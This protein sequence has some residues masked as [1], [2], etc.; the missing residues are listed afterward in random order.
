MRSSW[1]SCYP[2]DLKELFS[3]LQII[4]SIGIMELTQSTLGCVTDKPLQECRP[5]FTVIIRILRGYFLLT[6]DTWSF[7]AGWRG[8]VKILLKD[9]TNVYV[10]VWR[11]WKCKLL[12]VKSQGEIIINEIE[13]ELC[14]LVLQ[15]STVMWCD[16][17]FDCS[18][19]MPPI[20]PSPTERPPTHG[21][22]RHL[23]KDCSHIWFRIRLFLNLRAQGWRLLLHSTE[24]GFPRWLSGK[25]SACQ[26]RRHKRH[27]FNPW[28]GKISWR[29]E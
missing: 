26:C 21:K 1:R 28:V 23:V 27:G 2:S 17:R 6:L 9:W 29:R 24:N 8:T 20:V 13:T 22:E 12:V 4:F 5:H 19:T 25:E 18:C 3:I 11:K 16:T 15:A 14:P 10:Y 7:H